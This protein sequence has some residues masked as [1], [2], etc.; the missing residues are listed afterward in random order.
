MAEP[1]P[2]GLRWI[3]FDLD[4]TLH[5][6]KR[7]SGRAAEAVFGEIERECGVGAGDLEDAYREILRAAQGGRFSG[8]RTSREYRAERFGALLERFGQDPGPRLDGILDLYDAALGEALELRPGA[9]EALAAAR[10]A[11]LSVMV[12]SEGPHDAQERTVERLGIAPG[13]DLLVTSSGE[14]ASKSD[15]LFEKALA[16]ADCEPRELLYAGDSIERDIAPASA[17]GIATVYVG[18]EE[19]PDGL[20]P[21]RVDLAGLGRLLDKV[22][23]S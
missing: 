3:G 16:R 9:R 14:Q 20:A 19:P 21:I 8:S 12:I 13:I 6:Y 7:A 10:R 5:Y 22:D 15:G 1:L 4:D 23:R 11:R 18:E 17:L 2:S